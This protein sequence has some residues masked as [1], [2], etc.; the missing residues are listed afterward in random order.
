[1]MLLEELLHGL[2]DLY[3]GTGSLAGI[4][5]KLDAN[6][7]AGV[8]RFYYTAILG[9]S[10]ETKHIATERVA[11]RLRFALEVLSS[12]EFLQR[13]IA[14]LRDLFS[15]KRASIFLHV[16]KTGGST[17][18]E[19]QRRSGDFAMLLTP[20]AVA[21]WEKDRLAYYGRV[22]SHLRKSDCRI[23]LAG[24]P[25]VSLLISSRILR[26]DDSLYTI[27][28]DPLSTVVSYLNYI[29]TSV[30]EKRPDR[31]SIS[32]SRIVDMP[33][34]SPHDHVPA[35]VLLKLLE[36]TVPKNFLCSTLGGATWEE[37][38]DNIQLLGVDT[39]FIED[40]MSVIEN[41]GVPRVPSENVSVKFVSMENLSED[42]EA[43]IIE[44]VSE[45]MKLYA[46]ARRSMDV[47]E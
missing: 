43:S 17:V 24:H 7:R 13:H 11:D 18:I 2:A 6:P 41:M 29:L 37:A 25:G 33:S 20:D 36:T 44:H 39:F 30:M 45:D 21:D 32:W 47:Q 40:M 14:V 8:K 46:W 1:M 3:E 9:R 35:P 12:N 15:A 27:L 16:P 5:A 23:A 4:G 19:A 42:V 22:M 31:A 10:P 26:C 34:L 28:R 38:R